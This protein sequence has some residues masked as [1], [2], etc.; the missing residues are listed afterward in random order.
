MIIYGTKKKEIENEVLMEKCPYCG[1]QNTVVMHVIQK[2]VHIFWIPLFPLRKIGAT[3]CEFCK[4]VLMLKE[5]PPVL[6]T[7]Y[8]NLKAKSKTPVWTYTGLAI[9]TFFIVNG[10]IND[11]QEKRRKAKIIMAPKCGDVYEVKLNENSY[12]LYKVDHI[13]QDSI[14]VRRNKYQCYF[15]SDIIKLNRKGDGGY[16]NY[17]FLVEK[18]ELKQMFDKEEILNVYSK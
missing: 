12:T 13:K 14:Y 1:H 10:K 5:M 4:Q 18:S 9:L 2:Y 11:V 16:E 15:P 17:F 3:H 8:S 7:A 6:I